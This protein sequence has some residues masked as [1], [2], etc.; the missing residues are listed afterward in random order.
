MQELQRMTALQRRTAQRPT[1]RALI[2]VTAQVVDNARAALK[3]AKVAR[4]AEAPARSEIERVS[5]ELE[6]YAALSERVLSQARRRVLEGEQEK[7]NSIFEPHTDLIK[8]GKAN[9]PVEFGH[10]GLLAEIRRGLITDYQSW[11]AIRPMSCRWSPACSVTCSS[12]AGCRGSTRPTAAFTVG[13]ISLWSA[14]PAWRWR[15]FRNVADAKPPS[16]QPMRKA[17]PLSALRSFGPESKDASA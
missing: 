7:L 10:K 6:H 9:T 8:R 13:S 16:A 12:L 15:A 17:A 5:Q 14:L 3:V 1:Y 2:K 11:R 4:L